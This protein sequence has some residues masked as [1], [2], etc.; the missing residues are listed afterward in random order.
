LA[1]TAVALALGF[2]LLSGALFHSP[3]EQRSV[4]AAHPSSDAPASQV[5]DMASERTAVTENESRIA[6]FSSEAKVREEP[7]Q[8][9]VRE[10]PGEDVDSSQ[11][12]LELVT[13]QSDGYT[14]VGTL[15]NGRK[16]GVWKMYNH[17]GN[18]CIETSYREGVLHGPKTLR[19]PLGEPR[20]RT[21]FKEGELHGA[22]TRWHP[23]GQKATL[24]QYRAGKRNGPWL[25]WYSNGQ[26]KA[27]AAYSDD[28]VE[29]RCLF[30]RPDG[31]ID[32]VKSGVYR[33][34]KKVH[35]I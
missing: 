6:A 8:P 1:V 17:E 19:G 27:Q 4:V 23:N 20:S 11:D 5:V 29:G 7:S 35:D 34:G 25:E 30:Y 21:E 16:D 26:S 10:D 28:V 13:E 24:L 32:H 18:L 9:T 31:D 3:Q 2:S 22:F 12:V 14:R 15:L 33:A